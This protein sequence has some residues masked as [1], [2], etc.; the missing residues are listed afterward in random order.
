[1]P[2]KKKSRGLSANDVI[3]EIK[4]GTVDSSKKVLQFY[5]N[6]HDYPKNM[7]N[8]VHKSK[9]PN[10][11]KYI[12]K[13]AV[14]TCPPVKDI[15][16]YILKTQIP[17][18]PKP[19]NMDKYILKSSIVFPKKESDN[20]DNDTKSAY[21]KNSNSINLDSHILDDTD[22]K[23]IEN[24][25]SLI[26]ESVQIVNVIQTGQNRANNL[27]DRYS[28]L[29]KKVTDL[30]NNNLL[31]TQCETIKL[32]DTM[33]ILKKEVETL[34][35]ESENIK[36]I[37]NN[38]ENNIGCFNERSKIIRKSIRS[39]NDQTFDRLINEFNININDISKK[40]SILERTSNEINRVFKS[41]TCCISVIRNKLNTIK[42][43]YSGNY[44][45]TRNTQQCNVY[46]SIVKKA[47]VYSAY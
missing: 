46:K 15:S 27:L 34:I 9:M 25:H 23:S 28:V 38:L 47:D 18:C 8:Y 29:D 30:S 24:I 40:M 45:P 39:N 2:I 35:I 43:I 42:P 20:K 10:L 17:S 37:V 1:M 13:T 21:N 16:K 19:P 32:E 41:E 4:N 6:Q 3:S 14:P 22:L 31:T 12:R 36:Q 11:S 26:N 5:L 33:N 7:S 44:L